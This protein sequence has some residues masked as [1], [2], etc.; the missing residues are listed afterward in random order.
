MIGDPNPIEHR[1]G[2]VYWTPYGPEMLYFEQSEGTVWV[3]R[4]D[5]DYED[6]QWVDW[7]QVGSFVGVE[8]KEVERAAESEIPL[9]MA[10][11]YEALGSYYGWLRFAEEPETLTMAEAKSKYDGDVDAAHEHLSMTRQDVWQRGPLL[12]PKN[13]RTIRLACRVSNP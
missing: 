2:I 11:V 5:L 12:V 7:D 9:A 13:P 1:G 8:G 10:S 3:Y 6:I 4:V